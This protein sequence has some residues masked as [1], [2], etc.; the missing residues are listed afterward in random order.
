MSRKRYRPEITEEV[1]REK[2]H[3]ETEEDDKPLRLG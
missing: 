2:V 1:T 3:G